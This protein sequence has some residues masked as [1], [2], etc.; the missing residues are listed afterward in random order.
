[1]VFSSNIFL[2]VFFPLL[3]ILYFLPLRVCKNV[4]YKNCI[5]LLF[6]LGFYA[7]GEPVFI[8]L[9]L[10]SLFVNWGI[11][12]LIE[13]L[14]IHKWGGV[15]TAVI[16]NI[17]I[18]I[19]FKYLNFFVDNINHL[20]SCNISIPKIRLPIGIS[21]FSFQI[22]SYIIDVC[23]GDV[24]AQRNPFKLALY[25]FLFP[26][27]IAGPIVRYQTIEKEI[28]NRYSSLDDISEGVRRFSFGLGK[29]IL[30]ANYVAIIAD[31]IFALSE[32]SVITAWLGAIAYMLQIYF[33]FS[34][35]SDM[36]IGLGRIFGFHFNENFNYPYEASSVTDFWRRWHISLSS[37]FRDYVYIPLGG[38]RC[39]KARWIFNLFVVWSLTGFWHGA[40]WTFIAWGLYYFVFLLLEKTTGITNKK[41][42]PYRI[43]TLIIILHGWILFRAAN[44][45]S[46]FSY[47]KNMYYGKFV[48]EY[49]ISTFLNGGWIMILFAILSTSY[50]SKI[51]KLQ[52]ENKVVMKNVCTAIIFILSLIFCVKTTYNPFIYFNF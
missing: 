50:T 13:K 47:M 48:D 3:L 5:L 7:W 22:L 6:S 32:I 17:A 11:A 45:A 49:A 36:A 43:I 12:L 44:I 24:K 38:N 15:L 30:V 23:R 9:L 21:F 8:F 4:N 51:L 31:N 16:W 52:N 19:I 14:P 10:L 26:Q 25:A 35:Y 41:T 33:D 34:G 42:L 1:M 2:F 46:A 37:W 29:K 40:N 20:F 18:L 28:E 39:S 27:L